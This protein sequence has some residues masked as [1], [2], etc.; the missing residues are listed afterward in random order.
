MATLPNPLDV[1]HLRVCVSLL[2]KVGRTVESYVQGESMGS[3]LP[4]GSRVRIAAAL[5]NSL[6]PGDI[7]ACLSEGF[8][9]AHRLV[10]CGAQHGQSEYFLTQG[11][12]WILCDSPRHVSTIL[13][14]VEECFIVGQ[15]VRAA[16]HASRSPKAQR[17]ADQQ[18]AL[19]SRCLRLHVGLARFVA[20]RLLTVYTIRENIRLF[21]LRMA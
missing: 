5:P 13:G 4:D 14:K 2:H 7:I 1:E 11:D 12:G 19:L 16:P 17:A 21:A 6:Q 3:T 18:V 9:S 15:W 20:R 8:L 10:Y